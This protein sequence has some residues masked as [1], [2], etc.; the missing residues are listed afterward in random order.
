MSYRLKNLD[1]NIDFRCACCDIVALLI[2]RIFSNMLT[3][4]IPKVS[5]NIIF[6]LNQECDDHLTIHELSLC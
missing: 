5:Q 1:E 3:H 2:T 6:I 4:M